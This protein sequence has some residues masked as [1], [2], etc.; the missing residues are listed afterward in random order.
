M[1]LSLREVE[2]GSTIET[3][4]EKAFY[5]CKN[6][7]SVEFSNKLE[8]IGTHAFGYCPSLNSVLI[9]ESVKTI[10]KAAFPTDYNKRFTIYGFEDVSLPYALENDCNFIA[11]TKNEETG[12]YNIKGD[13]NCDGNVDLADVVLIMQALASPSK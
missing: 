4:G 5:G 10:G 2:L 6:L 12:G 3:I 11:I 7:E 1:C 9:P 13:A 8:T